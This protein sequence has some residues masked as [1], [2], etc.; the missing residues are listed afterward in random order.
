MVP[1]VNSLNAMV[2]LPEKRSRAANLFPQ[3]RWKR[4]RVS[5]IPVWQFCYE[6][7]LG[8]ALEM[9]I[10]AASET[11]AN[12]AEQRALVEIDRLEAIFSS[13]NADSEFRR[14]Q[15][16]RGNARQL[17]PE[18]IT[19]L[20]ACDQWRVQSRG[21]FNPASGEFTALWQKATRE[22]ALPNRE[23]TA[24]VQERASRP[25]WHLGPEPDTATCLTDVS[26]TLNAIAK[27]F[28]VDRAA[29]VVLASDS[30]TS[31]LISI[32]GDLC[33]AGDVAELVGIS[34][35]NQDADNAPPLTVVRLQNASLVTSGDAKRGFV[36]NGT[37]YSHLV[38]P[39]T[40]WP[41]VNIRSASVI[42]STTADADALATIVSVLEP[43]ESLQLIETIPRSACLLV[44]AT[45]RIHRSRRWHSF[46]Y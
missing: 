28:I 46:E 37:R 39:R 23:Q 15:A 7:V 10:H 4:Q 2:T 42:A 8:T 33:V 36:I 43:A 9:R 32:G 12:E 21:A 45:R 14:W 6:N 19:V 25:H 35:P 34:D 17:S 30:V 24:V 5:T 38:D 31:V 27:G 13:F 44:T 1:K 40:G 29:N 3:F 20:R 18:L 11:A 16:A 41:A 26:L 22:S